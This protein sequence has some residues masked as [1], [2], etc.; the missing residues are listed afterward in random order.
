[1]KSRVK[2]VIVGMIDPNPLNNGKGVKILKQNG[3]KV[4]VGFLDNKLRKVN[5]IFIKNTTRRLPFVT[6][7]VAQTLDGKIAT[8][9][10]DSKWI[11]SDKSRG[12]AHRL[13]QNYAAILVGVNTILRDNPRLNAWFSKKQPKKVIVDSQLSTPAN[14]N[15][16][17]KEA[18]VIIATL[19]SKPGQE[20]QNRQ[21]LNKK[22]R[23]LEVKEKEGQVNLKD[24]MR[25]LLRLGISNILVEGGGTLI[26]SL[27]D[28]GLV[29]KIIFIISPKIIGGKEAISSVMGKGIARIDRTIKLKEIK[30]KRIAEDILVEG[31]V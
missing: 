21:A 11:T 14:A 26:G 31:Y 16:F 22:A 30:I 3:V 15:I 25:K 24:M 4:K 5:E 10:G 9:T 12:Y 6:V 1:M 8:K 20:T 27:F 18:E 7:K 23:V 29:D 13:R 2:E 28:E 17:S 19:P